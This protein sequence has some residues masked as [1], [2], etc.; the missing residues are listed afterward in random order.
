VHDLRIELEDPGEDDIRRLLERHLT[1]AHEHS[2]PQDVHA[3]DLDGL[4]APE[5]SFYSGRLDGELVVVGALKELD[6]AHGELKSMHTAAESRGQG[7]GRAMVEHLV[8][9]ARRR[10]YRT[11][12]LETGSNDPFVPARTMYLR[13]GFVECGP[14]ADYE[15]S[16]FSTFMTLDL[17]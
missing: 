16:D 8:A 3:L 10:G 2:P 12:S 4:R 9:E 7:A 17:S 5:V 15:L 13:A 1:F 11:V 14:F 6:P